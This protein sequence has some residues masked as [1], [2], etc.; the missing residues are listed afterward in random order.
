MFSNWI[1]SSRYSSKVCLCATRSWRS[2]HSSSSWLTGFLLDQLFWGSSMR[3]LDWLRLDSISGLGS[4]SKSGF[5]SA[6]FANSCSNSLFDSCNNLMACCSCGVRLTCGLSRLLSDIAMTGSRGDQWLGPWSPA[7]R[8]LFYL[9]S[10][11][12]SAFRKTYPHS[13]QK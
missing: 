7:H 9:T 3:S 11:L 8:V 13:N 1:C 10:S 6:A 4:N 12:E 5:S 2:T